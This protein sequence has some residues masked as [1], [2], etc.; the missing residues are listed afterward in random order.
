MKHARISGLV[1]IVAGALATGLTPGSV[2]G[3]TQNPGANNPAAKPA[4]KSATPSTSTGEMNC[5]D[6]NACAEQIEGQARILQ[7]NL[8][9]QLA[10]LENQLADGNVMS[11]EEVAKLESLGAELGSSRDALESRA[12]ELAAQAQ[13][14]ASQAEDQAA[15]VERQ[16]RVRVNGMPGMDD[17]G[18]EDAGWLGMEI[19]EVTTENAKELKLS[20]VRGVVVQ[21]VEPDS[22]AAKAGL[23][24]KDVITEYDGQVVEG[25]LQFRRL[26]RETP[27][28]RSVTLGVSRDG[29]QETLNV[30]VGNRGA[31]E[32]R[33]IRGTMQGPGEAFA[34]P[35]PD[36]RFF[37][38]GP[39][40][41]DFSTPKLGIEAEDLSGQL[42]AYFGAPG[43]AGI[44]VRDVRE[45]TP[46]AKAGLKAGDV[47]TQVDGKPVKNL[48][49]LREELRDKADQ[50]SVSL[51]VL[52]KGATM[53]LTVAI[54]KPQ[55]PSAS[56]IVR[57]A[58]L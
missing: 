8:R 51:S 24:E 28:G 50:K 57:R 10:G 5:K 7:Q 30:V 32:E 16:V 47:I 48:S 44:L 55:P 54:E 38:M 6:L 42:G 46:A 37:A 58:Q 34:F 2:F 11:S 27:P 40:A 31:A 33:Q 1:F 13:D 21:G 39:D 49:E 26:V 9:K 43:D 36:V 20:A 41:M 52:R 18:G 3:Q 15:Q 29:N 56:G 45:G 19:G 25:T 14:M 53:N 22:P 35:G 17:Q 23:Q 12:A 4:Q